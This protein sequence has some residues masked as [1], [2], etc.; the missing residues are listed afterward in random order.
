MKKRDIVLI[1]V[2]L[3]AAISSTG[4]LKLVDTIRS[5]GETFAQVTY[6]GE[7]IIKINLKD[8]EEFVVYETEHKDDIYTQRADEGIFYVPG[9]TTLDMDDLYLEDDFAR[10]NNIVGIKLLVKDGKISVLYQES[11]RDLCQLEPPTSSSLR[12]I[13]CLPNKVVIKII[14]SESTDDF[15]PDSS[16]E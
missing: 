2:I 3:L 7:P 16:L 11:P 6:S 14:T 15:N 9:E 10:E 12:P 8:P 5:T 1:I 4:V 13:V